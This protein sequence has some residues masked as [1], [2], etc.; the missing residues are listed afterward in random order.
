MTPVRTMMRHSDAVLD[1]TLELSR[2]SRM[3]RGVAIM[4]LRDKLVVAVAAI[5]AL[6]A[7]TRDQ[8]A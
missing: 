4:V 6:D 5:D 8:P 2:R 1:V 3:A 7:A